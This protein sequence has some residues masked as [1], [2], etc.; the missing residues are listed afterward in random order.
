[1]TSGGLMTRE[2][3]ALFL[4]VKTQT[5]ADWACQKR[6]PA[7]IKIG[8]KVRYALTDLEAWLKRQ[9]V[10]NEQPLPTELEKA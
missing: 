7:L 5:L 6:G 10:A 2:E 9:R 8:S 3:A 1:M 4:D